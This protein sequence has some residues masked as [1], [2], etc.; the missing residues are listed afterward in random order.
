M[1]WV[2]WH[3]G[4]LQEMWV[5][6]NEQGIARSLGDLSTPQLQR[7]FTQVGIDLTDYPDGYQTEVNLAALDWMS[8]VANKVSRG[9]ILT[10]DYGYNA[11]RYYSRARNQG[12]LQC[13]YRHAHHND[14]FAHIGEQDITAH[15]D[16]TALENRGREVGLEKNWLCA[17]GAVFDGVG[18]GRS[19]L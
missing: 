7:Y 1:H 4:Q 10:I 3:R 16:F 5:V 6:V 13:Y 9:Y 14:P 17:A 11:Q 8:A 19:P 2:E 18:I 12:T 15:V